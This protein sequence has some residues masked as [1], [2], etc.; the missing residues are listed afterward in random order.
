[1]GILFPRDSYRENYRTKSGYSFKTAKDIKA[2]ACHVD[3]FIL[4]FFAFVG[5]LLKEARRR[6]C[7]VMVR[8]A[9][10]T[11]TALIVKLFV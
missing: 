4:F 8:A 2:I 6:W 7:C 10:R 11:P 3:V 1:V 5:M 9:A